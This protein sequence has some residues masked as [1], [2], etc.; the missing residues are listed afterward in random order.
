MTI[1]ISHINAIDTGTGDWYADGVIPGCEI[2]FTS[3][4][5]T[6]HGPFKVA[7]LEGTLITEVSSASGEPELPAVGLTFTAADYF[8]IVDLDGTEIS[9]Y[10]H[11]GFGTEAFDITVTEAL[12]DLFLVATVAGASFLSSGTVPGDILQMPEDPENPDWTTP[13]SWVIASVESETRV[14]IVNN[15]TNSPTVTNE[16]PHLMKR[17]AGLADPVVTNGAMYCRVLRDMTKNEQ[18]TYML[19]IAQSIDSKRVVLCYPSKVDI[20]GLVDGSAERFGSLDPVAAESQPGYYLSCAVGGQTAGQPPQQG[21]TNLGIN[22]IDR[23]YK[24]TDYFEEQQI[25][26]L[27]NGGVY[28]FVQDNP[29]ALPYSVHEVTTDVL[30]LETGEYMAVKDFDF[31]AWA[32]MDV[33]WDFI[34]KWNINDDTLKFIKQALASGIANLRSRVKPK[35][36]PPLLAGIIESVE[37][38]PDL[39]AD[40]VEIHCAVTLPMVLNTIGLHLVA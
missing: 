4:G 31:V 18:V 25:T 9:R 38:R 21:F 22:G 2:T 17:V 14:I 10:T 16:L 37:P 11:D 20:V 13:Q 24:S 33:L 26:D 1:E 32:L 40:R 19:Q 36:G 6:V 23:I 12:D 7:H 15:G 34:G 39:S 3:D 35:I 29:D 27:S 8:S 5:G 28:V 30:S